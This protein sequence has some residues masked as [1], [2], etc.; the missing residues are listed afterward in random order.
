MKEIFLIVLQIFTIVAAIITVILGVAELYAKKEESVHKIKKITLIFSAITA[1]LA[2]FVFYLDTNIEKEKDRK[3]EID[4]AKSKI[5]VAKINAIASNA[6]KT[7]DSLQVVAKELA[8]KIKNAENEIQVTKNQTLVL[9]CKN[10]ELAF[11]LE[12]EYLERQKLYTALSPRSLEQSEFSKNI[13]KIQNIKVQLE[14]IND[15][16]AIRTAGQLRF[17][18]HQAGWNI[19]KDIIIDRDIGNPILSGM[20]IAIGGEPIWHGITIYRNVGLIRENDN[21]E[22]ARDALLA[23]LKLNNIEATDRPSE[24][25]LEINTLRIVVGIKPFDLRNFILEWA[26]EQFF[27][28]R[29][30]KNRILKYMTS[31]NSM[32]GLKLLNKYPCGYILFFV[33]DQKNIIPLGSE[34]SKLYSLNWDKASVQYDYR[35][36]L[37]FKIPE[38]IELKSNYVINNFNNDIELRNGEKIS[39]TYYGSGLINRKVEFIFSQLESI[40]SGKL[41]I[42]GITKISK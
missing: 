33:D 27:D 26:D 18:F 30:L 11:K 6:Q 21:S 41:F 35:K 1:I 42:F 13:G 40:E 15:E 10:I 37:I 3:F 39:K 28:R 5:E 12:K 17:I 4:Q 23:Q 9:E 22:K 32:N 8:Y 36:R 7:S 24:G 38:I 34:I 16:E 25:E 29:E 14:T 2:I 20:A 19:I 31:Y